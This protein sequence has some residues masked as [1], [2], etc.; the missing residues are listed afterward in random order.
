MHTF[1]F[2]VAYCMVFLKMLFYEELLFQHYLQH[3]QEP[4]ELHRY[5]CACEFIGKS[6]V[7]KY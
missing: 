7:T 2:K 1:F 5:N 4:Q 3:T 6:A